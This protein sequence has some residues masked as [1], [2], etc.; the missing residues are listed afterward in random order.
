MVS[1]IR[2]TRLVQSRPLR[3]IIMDF[4]IECPE[5]G[6]AVNVTLQDVGQRRTVRCRRGHSIKLEDQP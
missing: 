4:D 1:D 6:T 2:P 3:G 5:C